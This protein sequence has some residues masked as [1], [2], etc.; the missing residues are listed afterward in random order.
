MSEP[1]THNH[2][3]ISR[4][5]VLR[6]AGSTAAVASATLGMRGVHADNPS[7]ETLK[8]GLIGAGGRGRGALGPLFW[9]CP[10]E[11]SFDP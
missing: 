1:L 10:D 8:V 2:S 7:G 6:A 5:D 9:S 3:A 11:R 4:R